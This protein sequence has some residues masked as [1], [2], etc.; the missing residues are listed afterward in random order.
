MRRKNLLQIRQRPS[1]GQQQT[2]SRKL[3]FRSFQIALHAMNHAMRKLSRFGLDLRDKS[4]RLRE[5]HFLRGVIRL[6]ER[7]G[8]RFD[9]MGALA[10][11]NDWRPLLQ[12][13]HNRRRPTRMHPKP[14]RR[15]LHSPPL[16]PVLAL[17]LGKRKIFLHSSGGTPSTTSFTIS[18]ACTSSREETSSDCL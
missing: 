3:D 18:R 17:L 11:Q 12:P 10:F 8:K 4:P 16:T 5:R 6:P 14:H 1:G 7:V 2:G 15:L 13:H 9:E